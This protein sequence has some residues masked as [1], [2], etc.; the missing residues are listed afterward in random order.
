MSPNELGDSI[1]GILNPIVGLLAS[2]LTF[3]AFYM[4]KI[5]N[6][7]IKDQLF[8]S[9]FYEMLQLHKENVNEI[10]IKAKSGYILKG[11]LVFYEMKKELETLLAFTKDYHQEELD[12]DM[13]IDAYEKYFLGFGKIVPSIN[14]N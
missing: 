6:D 2:I 4:Q 14:R 8:E 9:Q 5:A 12:S 7:E 13:F 10:E 11:R 3:L 1:G